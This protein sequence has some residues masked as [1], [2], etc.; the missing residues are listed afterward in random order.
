MKRTDTLQP[1]SRQHHQE[2][3]AC[4][5]LKKGIKK[6]TSIPIL[7]EFTRYFWDN[8]LLLH[9]NE[10][11]RQLVPLLLATPSL[12][13]YAFILHNDHQL[14]ETIFERSQNGSPSYRMLELF[15]ETL[16][17]HIRFEERV[18]FGAMQE[19][20]AA[21]DWEKLVFREVGNNSCESYPVK[22]WE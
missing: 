2:L 18:V 8:D 4:L 13:Q 20:L 16:E 14:I 12:K 10:E 5:L 3:L 11:E 15:V 7:Q 19:Q 6:E 21:G 1:L 9:V 22:F 17:Q